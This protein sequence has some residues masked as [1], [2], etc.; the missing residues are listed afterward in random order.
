MPFVTGE[1]LEAI[2]GAPPGLEIARYWQYVAQQ[3]PERAATLLSHAVKG[4]TSRGW[5]HPLDRL[6]DTSA[7]HLGET[8]EALHAAADDLRRLGLLSVGDDGRITAL[9]GLFST[10]PTDIAYVMG[11]DM[12]VYLLGPLAALAVSRALGRSGEVRARPTDGGD[13]RLVLGC[14]ESG[15]HSRDPESICLFLAAWDGEV[16]PHDATRGGGLFA[17]DD[18]LY[19]WQEARPD[20]HGMPLASMMFAMAATELGR[21]LGEALDGILHHVGNYA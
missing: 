3:L 20:V 7:E 1:A 21:D 17:D 15:I 6:I 10:E 2:Q 16:S 11:G 14:D 19:A 13:S 12:K 8:P 18:G 5:I 4:L 9:A